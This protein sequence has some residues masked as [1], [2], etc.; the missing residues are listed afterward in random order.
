M[1]AIER[2]QRILTLARRD[3][4]VETV[5]I[6]RELGI[7]EIASRR[8]LNSLSAAGRLTRVRGGAMLPGRDLVELVSSIIR[9]VVP[10]HEYY[11]ARIISGAEWAAKKLGSGL[12]LGMTH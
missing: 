3:G 10:T 5:Q 1:L 4:R 9:L 8:A 11:F 6:A 2:D 12:V 7:S